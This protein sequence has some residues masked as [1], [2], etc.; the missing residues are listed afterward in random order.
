MLECLDMS[1]LKYEKNKLIL[2]VKHNNNSPV[3]IVDDVYAASI[4]ALLRIE[5]L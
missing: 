2:K 1:W 3:D 5:K 4:V